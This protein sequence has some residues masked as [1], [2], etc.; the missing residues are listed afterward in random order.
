MLYSHQVL[1]HFLLRRK[2][3]LVQ[4]Y[5]FTSLLLCVPLKPLKPEPRQPV[6]VSKHLRFHLP[7]PDIVHENEKLLAVKIETAAYFLNKL[8]RHQSSCYTELFY[9]TTLVLSV[10][11]LRR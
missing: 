11:L 3:L 5:H 4:H 9:H 6:T 1:H 7:H 8:H 2:P 10:G